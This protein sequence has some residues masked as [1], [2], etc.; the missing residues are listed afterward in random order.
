M[1]SATNQRLGHDLFSLDAA[2][3]FHKRC[4]NEWWITQKKCEREVH[5]L[6]LVATEINSSAA[7]AW[8][9]I[10]C[11]GMASWLFDTVI[12]AIN[13]SKDVKIKGKN[14]K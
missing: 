8:E 10:S 5:L 9:G 1:K 13:I 14:S 6:Q 2:L 7:Q 11:M 12:C 3:F 4:E